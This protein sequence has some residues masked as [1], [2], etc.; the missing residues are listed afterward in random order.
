MNNLV[1]IHTISIVI[2]MMMMVVMMH[3]CTSSALG[4]ASCVLPLPPNTT[5]CGIVQFDGT[6]EAGGTKEFFSLLVF[7]LWSSSLSA[8]Q[9]LWLLRTVCRM[10]D[11]V[12]RSQQFGPSPRSHASD[13]Q[14]SH[15]R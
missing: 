5:H 4:T 1:C 8:K 15:D 6:G 13:P 11:I 10:S 9:L 2:V 14:Q 3:Q 7:L 12:Q